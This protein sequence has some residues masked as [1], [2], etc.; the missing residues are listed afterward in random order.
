[1]ELNC[2]KCGIL[3]HNV[4]MF[5][6]VGS[7]C[8]ICFKKINEIIK[9]FILNQPDRSKR[10]DSYDTDCNTPDKDGYIC[11]MAK[12]CIIWKSIQKLK[13]VYLPNH[14]FNAV[15][16]TLN[17]IESFLNKLQKDEMRCSEHCGN[18]VREVQ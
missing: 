16:D 5:K 6:D 4:K 9:Q 12:S 3:D 18:T 11:E 15:Q 17:K 13:N 2:L 8:D 10:E 1:M 14:G 7:L